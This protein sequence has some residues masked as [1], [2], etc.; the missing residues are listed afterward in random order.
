[1]K[2][3][4]S[5]RGYDN[6]L[7][8]QSYR[9]PRRAVTDEYGAMVERLEADNRRTRRETCTSATSYTMNLTLS[10]QGLNP[11]LGDEKRAHSRV[12]MTTNHLKTGAEP[13]VVTSCRPMLRGGD[14]PDDRGRSTSETSVNFYQATRRN[15][16]EDS[17]LHI[18]ETSNLTNITFL[19][20]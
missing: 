18:R 14:R 11:S 20:Q 5:D 4:N 12:S 7:L 10:H 17:D 9:T 15:N 8:G 6:L 13:T 19:I 16:P 2:P 3:L 1:M